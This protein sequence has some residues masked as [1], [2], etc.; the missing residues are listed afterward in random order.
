MAQKTIK[1]AGKEYPFDDSR[2]AVAYV[3]VFTETA[4][5]D[6]VCH[7]GLGQIIGSIDGNATVKDGVHLRFSSTMLARLKEQI[8]KLEQMAGA[9][10]PRN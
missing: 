5:I 2:A 7:L 9:Q 6:G 10:S 8:A 1:I 3:D 4:V